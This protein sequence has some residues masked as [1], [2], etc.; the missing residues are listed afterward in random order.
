MA[1]NRMYIRCG[2]C[3]KEQL[4][5]KYYPTM[6]GERGWMFMPF[7]QKGLSSKA[8]KQLWPEIFAGVINKFFLKHRHDNYSYEG[9]THFTIEY[10]SEEANP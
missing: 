6:H 4:I 9:P 2:V 8:P 10:E 5:A 1:N 3:G 7:P